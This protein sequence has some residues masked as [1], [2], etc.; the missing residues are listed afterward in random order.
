MKLADSLQA[1]KYALAEK[2]PD[3]QSYQR[4]RERIAQ[5][6]YSQC[7]GRQNAHCDC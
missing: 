5:T 7:R 4:F 2:T 1:K 3:E 6:R